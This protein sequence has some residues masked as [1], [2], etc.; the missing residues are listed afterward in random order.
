MKIILPGNPVA[1]IRMKFSSRNGIGRVYDLRK[2]EKGHLKEV[3][4]LKHVLYPCFVHPRVSFIF[5]MPIPKSL[6]KKHLWI[7]ESGF[8]KHEKKPDVD[9]LIKLYLDCMDGICFD[10]DQKVSLGAS[11]KLYHPFPKTIIV[12]NETSELL[13][14]L[15]VDPM[16]WFAL[17][18]K[19]SGRCSS[20]EMDSLPDFYTPTHLKSSLSS[21]GKLRHPR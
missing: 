15:E 1:Q 17:F 4:G 20:S 10:G 8:L 21:N 16:T 3:I 12:I 13:S 5:H 11:V 2:K 7:Y 19:E 14:P 9:N 18:G 6:P